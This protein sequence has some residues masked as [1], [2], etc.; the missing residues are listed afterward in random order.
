MPLDLLVTITAV[1][2]AVAVAI[3]ALVF[4]QWT[5]RKTSKSAHDH[6]A[7]WV[8]A[9]VG[10]HNNRSAFLL[11]RALLVLLVAAPTAIA[12]LSIETLF[13]EHSLSPVTVTETTLAVA[14]TALSLVFARRTWKEGREWDVRPYWVADRPAVRFETAAG[15]YIKFERYDNG[16]SANWSTMDGPQVLLSIPLRGKAPIAQFWTSEAESKERKLSEIASDLLLSRSGIIRAW[17]ETDRE[18]I[19][20]RLADAGSAGTAQLG[21]LM[22]SWNP[23]RVAELVGA[24]AT[25]PVQSTVGERLEGARAW[26]DDSE[27]LPG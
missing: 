8:P 1:A 14:A 10:D 20:W 21:V 26:I 11:T 22:R 7:K 15:H 12:G 25:G 2:V 19:V 17:V 13:T 23:S 4:G 6:S 9:R 16:V 5:E 27:S 18:L 24:S 3:A